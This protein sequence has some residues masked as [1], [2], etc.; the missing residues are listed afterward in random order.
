[1]TAH[2]HSVQRFVAAGFDRRTV[3]KSAGAGFGLL[4]LRQ[5]PA[6]AQD[7]GKQLV[8][9]ANF[10]IQSL[11][12]GRSIETTTNMIN[13]AAYDALV[14]FDGED[15]TTPKPLLATKWTIADDGTTYTFTLRPDVKF[16]S[17]NPLTSADVKWSFERVQHLESNPAF[18]LEKVSSVE[19]PDPQTVVLKLS[20][21]YPG[22]LPILSS[23]SL[24]I[25]DSKL[26]EQHGG[27]AGA[28]AKDS[29]TAEPFLNGQS[30]GSGSYTIS[31][32]VPD[33]E[34]VLVKNPNYWRGA[35]A[36]D[37]IVIRNIIEAATQKLQ[38][39]AGDIDIA[40]GL[41]QDQIAAMQ[42]SADVT[43]KGSPAAT[44]FYVLMN[45]DKEIGGPF[46]NPLIQQAVRAALKYDEILALVGGGAVRLA[47]IIPTNFP[48]SLPSSDAVKTDQDKARSLIDQA[49][50]GAINGALSYTADSTIWGVQANVLAQ[51]VQSDL[52]EV[53]MNLTLDGLPSS[54]ALQKYRDG[55]DQIGTWSWAADYPD[56]SDFLVYL[57][58]RTV[59]KRA[60]WP[61]DASPEAEALV[62]L[63]EQAET[64]VDDAKRVDLYQQVE[65]G[66]QKIGPYAPLFQPAV[67][68]AFR[69]DLSGV[70]FNSVWG[71][72]LFAVA[73][74]S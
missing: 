48:G 36:F 47:G 9:G 42:S 57:P 23:P 30:A 55:K 19:A 17:G 58:G 71:V 15:L 2:R 27:K 34:V 39:E 40:T 70:T 24:G 32:Y 41:S 56:A 13:H 37:R 43:T 49:G 26:V 6:A 5:R 33:Q 20:S 10:V 44:T 45:N 38:L 73:R 46:S 74:S 52:G 14:T 66:L 67:P 53:G 35:P 12:P 21:P 8:I 31:S 3:L 72:D 63:G 65:R 25:V 61:A 68:Y 11:D 29:D 4:V 16:V 1:M 64:T 18:L 22:I 50:L 7:S 69:S 51:K 60:G 62:K 28:D 54:T 59:G